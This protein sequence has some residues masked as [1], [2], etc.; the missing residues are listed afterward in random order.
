MPGMTIGQ[1][2]SY[3]YIDCLRG[4]AILLVITCHLTYSYLD[5]PYPVHRLTVL[6]WHGVQLFF[7]TSCLTLLMSWRGEVSRLG[8]AD[9]GAFF[10]RRVFR[11][12]PAYY[13][14]GLLYFWLDPPAHGFDLGQF[15]AAYGFVNLW[16]PLTAPTVMS[17]WSVIPGGWSVSVEFTFYALFPLIAF[18]VTSLRRA[19]F[20]TL[21]ALAFAILA[22]RLYFADLA[23]YYTPRAIED[24]LYFWFPN[25]LPVF[26]LGTVIFFLLERGA[27]LVPGRR[28]DGVAVVALVLFFAL[29]WLGF[30]QWAGESAWILGM[31]QAAALPLGL[32]VLALARAKPGF[33]VNPVVAMVGKISFSAYLLHYAAIEL[34]PERFPHL[35]HTH[36]TGFAAIAAYAG[37]WLVVTGATCAGAF[38]TYRAIELPMINV[39]REISRARR[40]RLAALAAEGG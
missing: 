11:I 23:G 12:I 22:N 4:Y 25:Q 24:I 10:I 40:T 18:A 31:A 1:K 17:Q 16:H 8:Q 32:F 6:G 38:C 33:F 13:L 29:S 27:F 39:A 9:I 15:L 5:L 36:A 14:G 28:A 26:A 20:F 2:W 19:V 7:L 3:P 37:G 30:P 35:F 21:G 34:L